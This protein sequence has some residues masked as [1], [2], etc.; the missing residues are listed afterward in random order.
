VSNMHR[1]TTSATCC[2]H[3]SCLVSFQPRDCV[4]ATMVI[5]ADCSSAG[6][7]TSGSCTRGD[8]YHGVTAVEML[9][10]ARCILHATGSAP[11]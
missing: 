6:N 2:L 5:S 1:H 11:G 4:Q 7:T 8:I 10:K 9:M 3:P